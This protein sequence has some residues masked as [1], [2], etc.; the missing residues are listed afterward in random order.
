M[1]FKHKVDWE[2]VNL[3]KSLA[4]LEIFTPNPPLVIIFWPS[5]KYSKDNGPD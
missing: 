4:L 5:K 2:D 1:S 3:L